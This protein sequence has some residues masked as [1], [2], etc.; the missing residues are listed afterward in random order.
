MAHTEIKRR[1]LESAGNLPAAAYNASLLIEVSGTDGKQYHMALGT[2]VA[3]VGGANDWQDSVKNRTLLTPPGSPSEGD[4]YIIA[5]GTPAGA[6]SGFAAGDIVTYAGAAW[7]QTAP[8][9][10]M[11]TYVEDEATDVRYVSGA[12]QT[13]TAGGGIEVATFRS[14]VVGGLTAAAF[15]LG[16]RLADPDSEPPLEIGLDVYD[17]GDTLVGSYYRSIKF[18]GSGVTVSEVDG[19]PVVAISGVGA[20]N[21]VGVINANSGTWNASDAP[22]TLA[23]VGTNG[24]ATSISGDTLTIDG[25]H[26]HAG[27][28]APVSHSH[29]IGN[30]PA[31]LGKITIPFGIGNAEKPK[32]GEVSQWFSV[33]AG[34][35]WTLPASLT[36][37]ID[38][39]SEA[40]PTATAACELQTVAAGTRL[41]GTPTNAG[42]IEVST[43]S[44]A[45]AASG[46]FSSA[47]NL[48]AGTRFRLRWPTSQDATWAGP[49]VALIFS[50]APAA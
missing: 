29:A 48:A 5:A 7:V 17:A 3:A 13:V 22:D 28:Y 43:G 39:M 19:K 35:T 11:R 27:V 38:S 30:L 41:A 49:L 14:P 31:F 23:I 4:R 21:A 50:R 9:L 8:A 44:V 37:A 46:D 10:G 42:T 16:D 20:T 24:V 45:A 32:A 26:N 1:Q 40:H 12:W 25:T 18:S 2:L 33:P 47:T 6:W 36:G 34:E 15:A